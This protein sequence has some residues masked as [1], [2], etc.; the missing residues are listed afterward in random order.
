MQRS[1]RTRGAVL[2]LSVAMLTLVPAG[3]ALSHGDAR[4]GDL[5][6]TIGFGTEPAYSGQP[7]SVQ[8]VVV[9]GGEPVTD[10]KP[11]DVTVEI[12][13]ADETSEPLD[14]EPEFFME[15]GKLVFGEAGDYRAFFTPSQPGKYTFHFKGTVD[16]EKIDEE[17]TS[18]P[19]TFAQVQD[20]GAS[21]FPA[22][23]APSGDE[24][25]TRIEQETGRA[26]E[27]IAAASVEATSANDA[28]SSARTVGMIG[29]VL[30]AIGVIAAIIAITRRGPKTRE[31][32]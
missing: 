22:V 20:L 32:A 25:A 31:R 19:K 14:M 10:L 3:V 12:T 6:M 16:G 17:M 11:G 26:D 5:E 23:N 29:I 1:L 4:Q 21:E 27:A 13:Y 15:N 24:L 8:L 2:A 18:G 7:N 28:A 9:H 30:G